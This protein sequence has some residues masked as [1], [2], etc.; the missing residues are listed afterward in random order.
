M[1]NPGFDTW[2][3]L[4]MLR[5]EHPT[6]QAYRKALAD[7]NIDAHE[8]RPIPGYY[9][10]RRP[11]GVLAPVFI[12]LETFE[13]DWGGEQARLDRVWPYCIDQ[14][15]PFGWVKEWDLLK[16]W[17]DE[18]KASKEDEKAQDDGIAG[19]GHNSGA[20]ESEIDKLRRQLDID[21]VEVGKYKVIED[22][23]TNKKAQGCRSHLLKVSGGH[24]KTMAALLLPHEQEID[25]IKKVWDPLV[26]DSKAGADAIKGAMDAWET[27]KARAAAAEARRLADAQREREAEAERLAEEA[28]AA[29]DRGETPAFIAPTTVPEQQEQRIAPVTTIKGASGRAAH[30]KTKEVLTDITDW[31]AL[32]LFFVEDEEARAFIRK[33]AQTVM[34]RTG[35][36]PPGVNTD[37]AAQVA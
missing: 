34:D 22:D 30:V 10:H 12:K 36:I 15:V 11:D 14:P 1:G 35:K 19:A 24:K 25:K 29:M 16:Q 21:L 20:T 31:S 2:R 13:V 27:K 3:L 28:E 37:V 5:Q 18:H 33:R 7:N 4:W 6:T 23:L 26:K 17:P 8:D 9:R 32:F